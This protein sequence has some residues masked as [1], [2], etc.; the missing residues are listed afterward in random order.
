MIINFEN[1]TSNK[2]VVQ[3]ANSLYQFING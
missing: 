2:Y 3:N 1:A